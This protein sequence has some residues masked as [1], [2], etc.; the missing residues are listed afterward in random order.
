MTRF[1]REARDKGYHLTVAAIDIDHFKQIND[2]Y[3]HLAGDEVL[4]GVARTIADELQRHVGQHSLYRTG[5][6]EFNI[7]FINTN[8]DAV[9]EIVLAVW[10]AVQSQQFTAGAYAIKATLS[11]GVAELKPDDK[12]FDDVFARADASLYQSKHNGRNAIT[13]GEHTLNSNVR[14]HVLA[15]RTLI[16]Q[17]VI[18]ARKDQA[19]V[20]Q[21]VLL[22]RYEYDHDRWNFP[23]KF[24]LPIDAQLDY[25]QQLLDAGESRLVMLHLTPLQLT[26]AETPARLAAF[27]E[28]QAV[29]ATLIVEVD[30][31][32]DPQLLHEEAPRYHKRGMSIAL[33]NL[34]AN[35]PLEILRKYLEVVDLL[36]VSCANLR[37]RYPNG[38][39]DEEI[40][41]WRKRSKQYGL[42]V[43]GIEN[44]VDADFAI[45]V[46]HAQYLQGYYFDRPELPRLA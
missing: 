35:L 14:H 8:L 39:G 33:I 29:S 5:G 28:K 3:G 30:H 34:D 27:I 17:K 24:T 11:I 22:A 43:T 31:S 16:S 18:D 42:I 6:E 37:R 7:V 36:K 46:M 13:I 32:I 12:R 9:Q 25:I 2:H 23:T 4:I 26:N 40:T 44:S 41:Q 10:K 15:T 38:P 19:V 20:A 21:E 45:R 1:F